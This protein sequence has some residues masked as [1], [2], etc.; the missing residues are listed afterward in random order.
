MT[1]SPVST[2]EAPAVAKGA[3]VFPIPPPLYY[4][5][6]FAAGMFVQNAV[7]LDVPARPAS[8]VVGAIIVVAGLA[9]DAAGV[10][11]VIAHHTTIVPHRPVAK[12]ITSGVYRFSRN[13]MYTGL[14]ILVTGGALLAGTWWPLVFLPLALVSVKELAIKP[15]EIYL[16]ERYGS[17]YADYRL[18]VRR[19]L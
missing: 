12:L 7:P 10:A 11:T 9:L 13:P 18:S 19:W 8:A 4:G 2:P 17:V 15:E 16:A 3:H 5:A 6:A 14:A 1:A